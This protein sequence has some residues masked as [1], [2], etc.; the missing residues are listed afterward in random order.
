MGL[1]NLVKFGAMGLATDIFAGPMTGGQG[2]RLGAIAGLF[3]P[4][5]QDM[6]NV[7]QGSNFSGLPMEFLGFPMMQGLFG[8][9]QGGPRDPAPVKNEWPGWAKALAVGAGAMLMGANGG[10]FSF[11]LY[12]FAA[13]L[14]PY[15]SGGAIPLA[16]SSGLISNWGWSRGFI[17]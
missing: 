6:D 13:G 15:N 17:M 8:N 7:Y 14:T 12:T 11:P 2:V 3:A 10:S 16:W 4:D 5:A 9:T 1:Q